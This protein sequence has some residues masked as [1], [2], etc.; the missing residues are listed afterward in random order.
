MFKYYKND[1]NNLLMLTFL[2][3]T[4][5]G[6]EVVVMEAKQ[7][8]TGYTEIIQEEF[9]ALKTAKQQTKPSV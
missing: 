8:L 5:D 1:N 3:H 2:T 7:D 6:Q 4:V 9:Q